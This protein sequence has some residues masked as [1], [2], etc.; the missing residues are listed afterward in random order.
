MDNPFYVFS[1]VVLQASEPPLIRYVQHM[2]A[3][4]FRVINRLLVRGGSTPK[5]GTDETE[6]DPTLSRKEKKI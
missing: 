1:S 3:L 4:V 2:R 6:Q 5:Y